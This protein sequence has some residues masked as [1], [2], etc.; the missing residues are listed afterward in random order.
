MS[1]SQGAPYTI[2]V[3]ARFRDDGVWYID[4]RITYKTI[5]PDDDV[6]ASARLDLLEKIAF[7]GYEGRYHGACGVHVHFDA[8]DGR[9]SDRCVGP[10][11]DHPCSMHREL[12]K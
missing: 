6:V 1:T 7:A 3:T 5:P 12:S 11:G 2:S 4:A 10:D 9:P 8:G